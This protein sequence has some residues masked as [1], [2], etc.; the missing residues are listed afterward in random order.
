MIPKIILKADD[1]KGKVY[2]LA[3]RKNFIYRGADTGFFNKW[4]GIWTGVWKVYEY[5]AYNVNG[6]WLSPENIEKFTYLPY[7]AI[8]HFKKIDDINAK[9]IVFVPLKKNS[10]VSVLMLENAS[11]EEKHVEIFL[12]TAIDV[13]RKNED[14]NLRKYKSSFDE[15]RNMVKVECE[16]GVFAYFGCD[17]TQEIDVEVE[18]REEY[19]EHYPG[20]ELQRC[21]IP[22]NYKVEFIMEPKE[23]LYLPFV[24]SFGK[25]DEETRNEYDSSLALWREELKKKVSH[26]LNILHQQFLCKNDNIS[27]LFSFSLNALDEFLTEIVPEKLAPIAG[28]PWFSEIWGRD[29]LWSLLGY[30]DAGMFKEAETTLEALASGRRKRIP[31][32]IAKEVN[33]FTLA[34]HAAD[35]DPLFILLANIFKERTGK[36]NAIINWAINASF[37]KAVFENFLAVH[38]SGETWMDSIRREGTAVEIQG[39]WAQAFDYAPN[40]KERVYG[41]KVKK[42]FKSA[43]WNKHVDYPFDTFDIKKPRG[44]ITPNCFMPMLFDAYSKIEER[45]ILKTAE[46]HLINEIGVA[47]LSKKDKNYVSNSYHCGATW[48]FTTMLGICC[49]LRGN[50]FQKRMALKMLE[51]MANE[52]YKDHLGFV[53]EVWDSESKVSIGATGQLWSMSFVPYIIDSLILGLRWENDKNRLLISPDLKVLSFLGD[54]VRKGKLFGFGDVMIDFEFSRISN[55]YEIIVSPKLMGK[56]QINCKLTIKNAKKFFVNGKERKGKEKDS[57]SFRVASRTVVR[58]ITK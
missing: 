17:F 31:C 30:I 21:Y 15:S 18:K 53:P 55:G 47:S 19:K 4:C 46:E 36:K 41:S 50:T 10:V 45:K 5:F 20:G 26:K 40:R 34:Y 39:L 28:Y 23:V 22:Y 16:N 57:L 42:V 54:V 56:K 29:A 51:N 2:S 52:V 7:A 58:V 12:E 14:F 13:R 25:N 32:F 33:N 43:F 11:E 48:G 38:L 9:E 3:G 24:Y 37:N 27:K 44:A 49:F 35:T 6:T 1:I 8:H